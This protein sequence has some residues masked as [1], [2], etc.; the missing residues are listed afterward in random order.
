MMSSVLVLWTLATRATLSASRRK[1]TKLQEEAACQASSSIINI[2]TITQALWSSKVVL[3]MFKV[4]VNLTPTITPST[5]PSTRQMDYHRTFPKPMWPNQSKTWVKS[6]R[7]QTPQT[8]KSKQLKDS[9]P[10][11]ATLNPHLSS[12][13]LIKMIWTTGKISTK[14]SR[15]VDNPCN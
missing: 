6:T 15:V 10:R 4:Q 1:M 5:A 11:L 3:T 13:I 12:I 2:R 9:S 14:I 7:T 8:T